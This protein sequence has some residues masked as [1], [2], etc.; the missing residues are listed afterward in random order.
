MQRYPTTLTSCKKL[1]YPRH[2]TTNT[3]RMIFP[4]GPA[5]RL[6]AVIENMNACSHLPHDT[7][8]P[9]DIGQRVHGAVSLCT[10]AEYTDV[11]V[12]EALRHALICEE[13]LEREPIEVV[14][15]YCVAQH[16]LPPCNI[17]IREFTRRKQEQAESAEKLC[18][19]GWWIKRLK[20][21]NARMALQQR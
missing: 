8:R 2:A 7:V 9:V 5:A 17:T 13:L 12:D 20:L 14:W 6:P 11:T 10:E 4:A 21:R 15:A 1:P 3:T 19:Y 18:D 16:V